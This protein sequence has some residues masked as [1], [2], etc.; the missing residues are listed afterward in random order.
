MVVGQAI[1]I[2][3]HLAPDLWIHRFMAGKRVV[4][5][6]TKQGL[7]VWYNGPSPSPMTTVVTIRCSMLLATSSLKNRSTGLVPCSVAAW[8]AVQWSLLSEWMSGVSPECAGSPVCL[9]V[10]T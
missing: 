3:Q 6:S 5:L 2:M 10:S 9:V 4:K 8:R 1:G 7:F